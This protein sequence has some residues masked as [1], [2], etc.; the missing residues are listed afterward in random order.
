MIAPSKSPITP[1]YGYGS[2]NPPYT[3][4]NPHAGVDFQHNPDPYIYAPD[5]GKITYL[6]GMGDCGTAMELVHGAYKHRFCHLSAYYVTNQQAVSRGDKIGKMGATGAAQ[7]VHLHWVLWVNGIRV[8]GLEYV[9]E[10]DSDMSVLGDYEIGILWPVIF[11]YAADEN[12]KKAWR[13]HESNTAI[14][15]LIANPS[16]AAYETYL[17]DLRKAAAGGGSGFKIVD[18]VLYEKG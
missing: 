15:A 1:G 7:G 8:N 3:P 10:E 11:G 18:K 6:G 4:S 16:R 12:A 17:S 14:R 5:D 2:T 13:G 9:N